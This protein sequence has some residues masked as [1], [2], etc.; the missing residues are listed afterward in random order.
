MLPLNH[1]IGSFSSSPPD[2]FLRSGESGAVS[3]A[4]ASA[5]AGATPSGNRL[6]EPNEFLCGFA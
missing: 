5:A 6:I 2:E 4:A 3:S 1:P